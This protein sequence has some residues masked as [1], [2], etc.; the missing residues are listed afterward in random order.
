[1]RYFFNHKG[2]EET[3]RAQRKDS[4]GRQGDGEVRRDE[5]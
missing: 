4:P 1:M 3:Q 5:T 2:V